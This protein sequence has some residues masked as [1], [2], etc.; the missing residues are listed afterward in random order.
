[1]P[2][3]DGLT[4]CQQQRDPGASNHRSAWRH[5]KHPHGHESRRLDFVTKPVDQTI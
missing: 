2:V 1:M 4:P 3:M 5:G